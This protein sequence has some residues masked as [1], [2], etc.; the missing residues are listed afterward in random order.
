[1]KVLEKKLNELYF[2]L[3]TVQH[4]SEDAVCMTYNA[5]SKQ[6][7]IRLIIE[8]IDSLEDQLEELQ[9]YEDR[10]TNYRRTADM[11]CLCW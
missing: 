7:Y 1:M 10:E 4:T 11:P 6:E 2:K 9:A 8:E 5:D 3:D